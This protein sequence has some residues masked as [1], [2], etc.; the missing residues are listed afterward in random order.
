VKQIGKIKE[1]QIFPQ[2][3]KIHVDASFDSG[4]KIGKIAW[5]VYLHDE[6]IS[7]N[8][9]PM[10]RAKNAN[11]LEELVFKIINQIYDGGKIYTDSA[12][13]W[14]EWKG[15]NKNRI[16]LIDS[17]DNLADALLK[18]K[19]IPKKYQ[20]VP[21]YKFEYIKIKEQCFDEQDIEIVEGK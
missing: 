19:E 7:T 5:V 10:I 14:E 16:Y 9:L 21:T 2:S 17:K 4:N 8:I 3:Y 6:L 1:C 12:N 18:E 15:K 13:V 11:R 20:K